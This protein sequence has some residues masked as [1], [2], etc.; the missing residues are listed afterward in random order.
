MATLAKDLQN[1]GIRLADPYVEHQKRKKALDLASKQKETEE[2]EEEEAEEEQEQEEEEEEAEEEEE[3][4]EEIEEQE[5]ETEETMPPKS[6]TKKKKAAKE[7]PGLSSPFAAMTMHLPATA[8]G[9]TITGFLPTPMLSARWENFNFD[10]DCTESEC[11]M[12]LNIPSGLDVDH[13]LK[14][15]FI[16]EFT[17]K[18]RVRWPQH[19]QKVMMQSNLDTYLDGQ[20]QPVET[21]PRG[22]Q[23]YTSMA[24]NAKRLKE[25]D[26]CIWSEGVFKFSNAMNMNEFQATV[27]NISAAN[28][29]GLILQVRFREKESDEEKMSFASPIIKKQAGTM[30]KSPPLRKP[31]QERKTPGKRSSPIPNPTPSDPNL[32]V[33]PSVQKTTKKRS[34][35]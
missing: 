20:G 2:E 11:I 13:D 26:N 14:L 9:Q 4:E 32:S 24:Q 7:S 29:G 19:Y 5:E 15:E 12:R 35:K 28:G 16:D 34:R 8:R 27:L 17:F 22:H 3:E 30:S 31:K 23:M 10:K 1:R 18:I 33:D 25:S 21:F 6:A